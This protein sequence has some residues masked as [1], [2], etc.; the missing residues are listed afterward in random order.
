VCHECTRTT[1]K[2]LHDVIELVAY[3]DDKRARFG[4][5]W[6]TG[7]IG[8][9]AG[10]QPLPYDPRVTL[11]L[12]SCLRSLRSVAEHTEGAPARI[13]TSGDPRAVAAWL[14]LNLHVV[15]RA[16][17][18]GRH[19]QLAQDSAD[20]VRS[21][22][23]RPPDR[24]YV[25]RCNNDGCPESLYAAQDHS[26]SVVACPRCKHET[27]I[28]ERREELAIGVENYLG[29][30][31]EVSRL[32]RGTLGDDVSERMIRSLADHGLIQSRGTRL[33]HD[34]LLRPRQSVTYRIGDVR[35][36]VATM[37]ANRDTERAVRR[38]VRQE[39]TAS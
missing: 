37:R 32:L 25:G 21:L 30:V 24:I 6:R 1:R 17:A 19:M 10:E 4:S 36:A 28:Q 14:S 29:T 9:S 34:K 8:R 18:G 27:P 11:V 16:P 15:R 13:R 22:F 3:A 26:A 31:R 20:R 7:S 35:Q 38:T 39:K 23:D 33:E 12:E 5:S 2:R